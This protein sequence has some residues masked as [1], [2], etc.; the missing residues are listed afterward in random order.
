MVSTTPL[1]SATS[2]ASFCTVKYFPLA[3]IASSWAPPRAITVGYTDDLVITPAVLDL[4]R[5][6]PGA[7]VRTRHLDGNEARALADRRVDALGPEAV[8]TFQDKLELIASGQ[9]VAVLPASDRRSMLRDD[10]AAIP[11]DGIG[12]GQVVVVTRAG[13]R[14]PLVARFLESAKNLI[15]LAPPAST[16]SP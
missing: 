8:D 5:R 12:P 1:P 3:L 16:S 7:H 6:H 11:I 13:E 9:A 14:N 2:G 15:A 4:R 10:L